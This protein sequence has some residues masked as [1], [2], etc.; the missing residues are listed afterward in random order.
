VA[1]RPGVRTNPRIRRSLITY[2]GAAALVLAVVAVGA[3]LVGRQVAQ[4]EALRDAERVA[5]RTANLV[6]APLLGEVLAGDVSRRPELDRAV[7]NRIRDG[8]IAELNVWDRTGTVI[9][10]DEVAEIGDAS[11]SPR[12]PPR[13][14]TPAS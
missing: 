8:S 10:A 4:D 13:R 1:D 2:L 14:S 9:Y 12:R 7:A 6:V 5:Q 11:R 3:V